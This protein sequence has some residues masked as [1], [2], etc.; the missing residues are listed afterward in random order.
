LAAALA[1]FM[2]EREA[3][4]AWLGSLGDGVAEVGWN[5]GALAPWGSK[6]TA[7]DI[8]AAW[9]AHDLLHIRQLNEL[10]YAYLVQQ[11]APYSARYAGE[12]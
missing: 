10:R 1:D 6:L 11:V 8:M 9:V 7:G 4:L 3:S 12:W 5:A 2:A